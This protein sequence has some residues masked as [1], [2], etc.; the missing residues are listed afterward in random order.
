MLSTI[1]LLK[2]MLKLSMRVRTKK[3]L[4]KIKKQ[5]C[6]NLIDLKYKFKGNFI[7]NSNYYFSLFIAKVWGEMKLSIITVCYNEKYVERTL[8]SISSQTFQDF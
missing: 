3:T 6:F 7:L 5:N 8:K 1:F 4:F 2:K